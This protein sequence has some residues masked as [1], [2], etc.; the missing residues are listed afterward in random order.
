MIINKTY[1][2]SG[3]SAQ[4]YADLKYE[5]VEHFCLVITP[6]EVA[7]SFRR[8][9]KFITSGPRFFRTFSL[10]NFHNASF[11]ALGTSTSM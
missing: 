5:D 3:S 11:L 10:L 8:A 1:V 6:S 7:A 2:F 4:D 9:P